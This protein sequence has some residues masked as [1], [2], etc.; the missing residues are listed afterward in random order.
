MPATGKPDSGVLPRRSPWKTS[1]GIAIALAS[2]LVVLGTLHRFR[3]GPGPEQFRQEARIAAQ[4]ERWAEAEAALSRLTD[5]T[6]ED[7]LLRAVVATSLDQHDAAVRYLD[8]IPPGGPFAARV[9][10]VTARAELGC[11]RARPMEEALWLALR[12]DPKAAEARR[13]LVYLY[14][15]QGRRLE[16]LEQFKALC[17]QGPLTFDLVHHWCIAHQSQIKEPGE[18]KPALE[19][20]VENDADDR[21]SRLGLANVYRQLGL[22]DRAMSCLG[23]LPDSDPDARAGRAEIEF[24]RGDLG[25]VASL[26]AEGPSDHAKLARLRGR[27]ALSRDDGARAVEFYQLADKA[28][29]ND[30]ETLYG[31]AQ[32]LRIV[33]DRAAAEPYARRA[34]AH[35]VLREYLYKKGTGEPRSVVACRLAS[36]C[37]DVGYL[38][39]ARAWYRLAISYDPLLTRAQQA[40]YRL[41]DHTGS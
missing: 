17:E 24:D 21:W 33:G 3:P 13:L 22:F 6:S 14:G 5:L 10:L 4:S 11:Y 28:E 25:A 18:L 38:P 7:W 29:P 1:L 41:S 37:E 36:A 8:H 30:R 26:L 9:A 39:E 32:A 35:R 16:L 19:K 34:E 40:L 23:H 27:L 12:L 2:G 15:T 20:F 31:L